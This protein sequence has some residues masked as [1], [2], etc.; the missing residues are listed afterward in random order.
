[1]V[2]L[3]PKPNLYDQSPLTQLQTLLYQ[4]TGTEFQ[5]LQVEGLHT[6]ADMQC[7]EA[8]ENRPN[9]NFRTCL[10]LGQQSQWQ[11]AEDRHTL[12]CVR[13]LLIEEEVE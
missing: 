2:Q 6:C 4:E 3:V 10:E 5:S 11:G 9:P 13:W 1:M 7:G 8:S 12:H